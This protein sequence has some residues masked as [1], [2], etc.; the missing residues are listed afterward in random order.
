MKPNDFEKSAG[1]ICVQGEKIPFDRFLETTFDAL[2]PKLYT[3]T[4]SKADCDD[5]FM[6]SIYKF[7][8]K[9]V[10]SQEKLPY[11]IQGYIF[12]MCKNAWLMKKRA[13]WENKVSGNDSIENFE[14]E[15]ISIQPE[16]DAEV[17]KIQFLRQKA[18][19][20]AID[21]LCGK[22]KKLI[23]SQLAQGVNQKELQNELGY[24]T[25]Q[26]LMQAKY[27]CKKRLVKKVIEKLEILKKDKKEVLPYGK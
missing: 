9:F 21:D 24:T 25:Y 18:L 6:I 26:A 22:C 2:Y 7:W 11:N 15:D 10:A 13:P 14:K 27:N 12:M 23:E 4:K 19:S 8:E 16:E 5:I 1:W 3:L 17:Q 20:L